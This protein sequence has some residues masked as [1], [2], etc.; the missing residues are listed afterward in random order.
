MLDPRGELHRGD[1]CAILITDRTHDD[2]LRKI[3]REMRAYNPIAKK[4]GGGAFNILVRRLLDDP[5]PRNS[6]HS[7]LIQLA[8]LAAYALARRDLPRDKLKPYKFETYFDIL[9]PVL[10]KSASNSDPQG[11]VYFP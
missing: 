2:H 6:S 9:D 8:D 7:Y 10:L 11:V 5:V 4:Y 3:M 1:E